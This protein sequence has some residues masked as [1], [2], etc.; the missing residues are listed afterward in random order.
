VPIVASSP[1][2]AFEYPVKAW[3]RANLIQSHHYAADPTDGQGYLFVSQADTATKAGRAEELDFHRHRLDADGP[4]YLDTMRCSAFGHGTVFHARIS[5]AGNPYLWT[6]V[7]TVDASGDFLTRKPSRARYEAGAVRTTKDL[8]PFF[9][10]RTNATWGSSK[11]V[12]PV[13]APEWKLCFRQATGGGEVYR[14][15]DEDGFGSTSKPLITSPVLMK[16]FD[17][18]LQGICVTSESIFRLYGMH[19]VGRIDVAPLR[20]TEGLGIKPTDWHEP[21][22]LTMIDG[23][24]HVGKKFVESLAKRRYLSFK[25]GL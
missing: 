25:I 5:A 22:G 18:P 4:V 10:W 16:G 19:D 9:G 13:G 1:K 6:F 14:L 24:L 23:H 8:E 7:E 12:I 21:E 15:F 2:Q 3:G 20:P 17:E 11:N